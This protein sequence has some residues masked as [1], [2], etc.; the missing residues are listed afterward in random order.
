METADQNTDM[1][2]V[3]AI[4]LCLCLA[5]VFV[6]SL[7]VW[8]S[9]YDREHPTIIKKRFFSVFIV[10]LVSPTSLY[11]GMNEKY[12]E[13]ATFLELLGIRWPGLIQAI[14]MPLLLTM[15]LFLGPLCVEDYSGFRRLFSQ[16]IYR[17]ENIKTLTWWRGQ[18]VAP[19]S[20]E[21]TFRASHFHHIV[22][23]LKDGVTLKSAFFM[24]C[25]HVGYTTVFGAYAAFLFVQTGHFVAPLTVHSFCNGVELPDL[26]MAFKGPL[27]KFSLFFIGLVSFCLLLMPMTDPKL[28]HNDLFW[29]KQFV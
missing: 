10:C 22:C 16:S 18:V 11:F 28:F 25:Y 24:S 9:P 19:L 2:C 7:Y 8:R 20:E 12:L 29:H 5:V 21:W 14:V 4:L 1:C 13:K 23:R 17:I 26:T 15:I 3:S 27:R 6:A